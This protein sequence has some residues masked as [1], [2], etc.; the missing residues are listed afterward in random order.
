MSESPPFEIEYQRD[1]AILR[2]R[3]PDEMTRPT[4]KTVALKTP[5]RRRIR[6]H[7]RPGGTQR[8]PRPIGKGR[9]LEMFV[10]AEKFSAAPALAIGLIDAIPDDPEAELLRRIGA[11][12]R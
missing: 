9:A 11:V 1:A 4:R 12:P 8:L 5:S 6:T 10:G 7:H 2:L 3:S